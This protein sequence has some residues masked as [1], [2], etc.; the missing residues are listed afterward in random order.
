MAKI[1][2][3]KSIVFVLASSLFLKNNCYGYINSLSNKK[4]KIHIVTNFKKPFDIKYFHKKFNK[5]VS[6]SHT[7]VSRGRKNPIIVFTEMFDFLIKIKKINPDIIHSFGLKG[8][9]IGSIV[10]LLLRKKGIFTVTG[11]GYNFNNND[12]KAIILRSL[13]KNTLR[14]TLNSKLTT[15]TVETKNAQI[16]VSSNFKIKKENIKVISGLG[17]DKSRFYFSKMKFSRNIVFLMASRLLIDKG[18]VEF[19]RAANIAKKEKLNAKF[20]LVGDEDRSNQSYI[21]RVE[22]KKLS[23]GSV[24]FKPYKN[25]IINEILKCNVFVL[26]SYHE[27]LSLGI[28]EACSI[29]RPTICTNISGCKEIIKN[30]FSGYLVKKGDTSDLVD[31]FKISCKSKNKLLLLG[32][33]ARKTIEKFYG[34]DVISPKYQKLYN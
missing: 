14:F 7:E 28:M 10:S 16:R 11:L 9:L 2:I 33:N 22:L 24:H 27:G 15:V 5:S 21:S 30:N 20:I 4:Y 1:K 12:L 17:V 29:G 6:F 13:V 26:P 25:N 18:V 31:K 8:T 32:R 23:N 3:K 19:C 34:I